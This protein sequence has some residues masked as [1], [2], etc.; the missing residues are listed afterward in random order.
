MIFNGLTAEKVT[1]DSIT[2]T[3]LQ[4]GALMAWFHQWFGT[5][6]LR[7]YDHR[8]EAEAERDV[9]AIVRVLAPR[10]DER[11]LDLCCGNG[12]H[13]LPLARRGF[14]V[15]G[16]DYSADLL[17]EATAAKPA[18]TRYPMY[19]RGDALK[20]PFAPRSFGMLLNLF[21]SFGYF[22]DAGNAAMLR[23]AAGLLVPGGSFYIDYLNP[24]RVLAGLVPESRRVKHGMRIVERRIHNRETAR[25]EK[26]I[27]LHR[28]GK[29]SE[30]RESVR[31][32]PLAEMEQ[33][34]WT[35]GLVLEGVLGSNLG[36]PYSEE[37]TR[38]ILH[39]RRP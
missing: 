1:D 14:R 26:T 29:M 32:Y 11:V 23:S 22:D 3:L 34:I 37:S 18:D 27:E 6:Y 15:T 24:P 2:V 17:R 21:T 28:E 31:L 7:V 38:M 10:G 39:G 12:R 9:E 5:D 33:L 16:F 30:Y 20:M 35:A 8:D 19:V 13:D 4:D 36:E 25:V